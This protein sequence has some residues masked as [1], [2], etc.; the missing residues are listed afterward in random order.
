[1][2]CEAAVMPPHRG[3]APVNLICR[4]YVGCKLAGSKLIGWKFRWIFVGRTTVRTAPTTDRRP[5]HL[6]YRFSIETH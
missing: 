5:C 4:K 2:G 6:Q 3:S 1:V